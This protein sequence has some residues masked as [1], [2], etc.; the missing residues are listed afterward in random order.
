MGRITKDIMERASSLTSDRQPDHLNWL[1]KPA[2]RFGFADSKAAPPPTRAELVAF[3]KRISAMRSCRSSFL[4]DD[5]LGEPG[6][7]ML[8]ALF[9]ANAEEHS[10]TV[11]DLT[12]ASGVPSTTAL[13]WMATLQEKG[14]TRRRLNNLDARMVFIELEPEGR[15]Q[16]AAFLE[17]ALIQFRR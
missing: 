6:Y 4:N 2:G 3:A 15:D 5:L 17:K 12:R 14:L 8:L 7:D 1:T 11:S 13:R 10:L 9:I 16:V